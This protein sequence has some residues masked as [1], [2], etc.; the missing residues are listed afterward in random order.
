MTEDIIAVRNLHPD[1]YDALNA[2]STAAYDRAGA[3]VWARQQI[4]K[5]VDLFP[6][7]QL[8]VTVGD[9]PVAFALSMIVSYAQFGDDHSFAEITDQRRFS[10]HDRQG[11]VLTLDYELSLGRRGDEEP[12]E[13]AS[14]RFAVVLGDP[15]A[16]AGSFD[17]VSVSALPARDDREEQRFEHRQQI[18]LE[19]VE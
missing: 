8:C 17:L 10:N 13:T 7:G 12:A 15:L 18:S 1:D 6:E 11:D 3:K 19:T 16:Q 5:L 4:G 2:V 14:G 9:R